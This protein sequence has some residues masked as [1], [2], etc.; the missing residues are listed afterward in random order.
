MA[1]V[2]PSGG[3]SVSVDGLFAEQ[4]LR[5]ADVPVAGRFR[6]DVPHRGLGAEGRVARQPELQ[7]QFVGGGETRRPR[8]RC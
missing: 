6:E 1:S 2:M 7:S 4:F 5:E 8:C 3:I